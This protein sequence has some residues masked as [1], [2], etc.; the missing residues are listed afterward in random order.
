MSSLYG[1]S[2]RLST[3]PSYSGKPLSRL[4]LA[5]DKSP[6]PPTYP[7]LS[8]TPNQFMRPAHAPSLQWC[9][10]LAVDLMLLKA[11]ASYNCCHAKSV[12]LSLSCA[13]VNIMKLWYYKYQR[14]CASIRGWVQV[15]R[16]HRMRRLVLESHQGR[17][18]SPSY[19]CLHHNRQSVSD[20]FQSV[21]NLET[22]EL[23]THGRQSSE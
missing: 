16:T 21:S 7:K 19:P 23:H 13:I 12:Q 18:K 3:C 20:P 11:A 1:H 10:Y 22:D 17:T 4:F 2:T 5:I 6:T 14:L 15:P 8:Y 9:L